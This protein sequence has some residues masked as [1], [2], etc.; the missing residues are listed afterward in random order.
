MTRRSGTSRCP[1]VWQAEALRDARLSGLDR[2]TFEEHASTCADCKREI[3]LLAELDSALADVGVAPNPFAHARMRAELLRRASVPLPATRR[4]ALAA[5]ALVAAG[6][7]TFGIAVVVTIARA[8]RGEARRDD[9]VALATPQFETWPAPGTTLKTTVAGSTARVELT[10]GTCE[11]LVAPL[12]SG[13]RFV[14]VVPDGEVETAGARFTV[15]APAGIISRIQVN[16][17]EVVLRREPARIHLAAGGKWT[18]LDAY[19]HAPA[20]A[21]ESFPRSTAAAASFDAAAPTAPALP[22]EPS[23]HSTTSAADRFDDAVA[24]FRRGDYETA[25]AAFERFGRDHG[26]DSRAEDAAYLRAVSRWR[27]GDHAR[28]RQLARDYLERYPN[29]L[30]T[31]E[32]RTL[33][34]APPAAADHP[35]P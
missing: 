15:E 21:A 29:G 17:G 1:R 6:A 3:T 13:Q 9:A 11:F 19:E 33:A 26:N 34:A 20:E 16:E 7:A 27:L 18:R 31:L 22:G 28:A 5:R 2:T 14:V 25:D 32:A 12:R 30:R 10:S 8:P 23:A 35:G 24:A 4:R